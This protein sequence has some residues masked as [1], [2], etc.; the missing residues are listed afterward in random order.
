[1]EEKKYST[2]QLIKRLLPYFKPYKKTLILDLFC[3]SLTTLCE[4]VLPMIIRHIT[5]TALAD[6]AQLTYR[7]V[8]GMGLLYFL[9][10]II[11]SAA[12]Y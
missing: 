4:I 8:L 2:G 11:D 7:L 6:V 5:N 10:R 1:M 12:N 9:L 3:A